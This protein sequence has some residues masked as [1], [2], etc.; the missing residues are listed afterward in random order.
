MSSGVTAGSAGGGPSALVRAT[1]SRSGWLAGAATVLAVALALALASLLIASTGGSP[2]DAMHALLRGSVSDSA[3]IT[4][5][6]L[7]AAPLLLVGVGTCVS[8]R[9]GIFNIG[10]EGQ[11]LV[12]AL[13]AAWVALR[14]AI[15]GPLLAILVV[16]GGAVGGA[17]WAGLSALMHRLRGVNIVVSTLLM[18]FLAQQLIS[19]AVGTSWF[20]QQSRNGRAYVDPKSNQIPA[21][22]RLGSFGH[23]PNLQINSGLIIAAV[24]TVVIAVALNRARWG[25]RVRMLGLNPAAARHAG[26]R[27]AALGGAALMLSGATAGVA[28]AVLLASPIGTTRLEPTLSNNIGWDGLLVALVARNRPL[29]CAPVAVLF[30]ILRAGGSFLAATGV[31]Y[32]LV[33]VVKGLL[34]L[35]LV[36]P[37]VASVAARQRWATGRLPAAR[38]ELS[39]DTEEVRV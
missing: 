6:L 19:Y 17:F 18:T 7:Y 24:V 20:L 9:A 2:R 33:D 34:V 38:P 13:G 4:N 12:G 32:Y 5:T 8:T 36:V 27:V 39:T 1:S 14:F 29:L 21:N 15:P 37:S 26:V 10:Q 35:A 30:G 22:A 28:G 11:V 25:F 3:S 16:V 31:P 23:Y